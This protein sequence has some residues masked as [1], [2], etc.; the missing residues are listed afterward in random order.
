MP[1]LRLNLT[2]GRSFQPMI[3]ALLQNVDESYEPDEDF[4]P[5]DDEIIVIRATNETARKSDFRI[6]MINRLNFLNFPPEIFFI[7]LV[8]TILISWIAFFYLQFDESHEPEHPG[9]L[10]RSFGAKLKKYL[11]GIE[12]KFTTP[13]NEQ[14]LKREETIVQPAS[15][16]L[17]KG[18]NNVTILPSGRNRRVNRF[19][20]FEYFYLQFLI[21]FACTITFGIMPPLQPFSLLPISQSALKCAVIL[22]GLAYPAGCSIGLFIKCKSTRMLTFLTL[23]AAFIVGFIFWSATYSPNL[24]PFLT[25]ASK[26]ETDFG[27]QSSNGTEPAYTDLSTEFNVEL[28]DGYRVEY[29]EFNVTNSEDGD[30]SD[31]LEGF[32]TESNHQLVVSVF[33]I[34]CWVLFNLIL[35]YVKTMVTVTLNDKN[36]QEAL[37]YVGLFSQFGS[38]F[39]SGVMVILV[40]YVKLF[41]QN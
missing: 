38:L 37:F 23:L 13:E 28:N 32:L 9:R 21:L 25:A 1:S 22:S 20:K 16:P 2:P 26:S 18:R 36:G 41:K 34:S 8:V 6:P 31:L 17:I 29:K 19:E 27:D 5:E 11:F 14:H 40:N 12:S 24:P 35:S 15:R 39:G 10:R 4:P 3:V 30:G 33:M 7:S